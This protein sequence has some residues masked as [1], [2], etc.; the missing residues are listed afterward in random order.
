MD[1]EHR[2]AAVEAFAPMVERARAADG[3]LDVAISADPLDPERINV[4]ERW[5]DQTSLDAW[6]KIANA[7]KIERR[8]TEVSLYRTER[9][10]NPF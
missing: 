5:R 2:D 4:F 1:A 6:R 10:E 7:P 8:E 3:C 9:A